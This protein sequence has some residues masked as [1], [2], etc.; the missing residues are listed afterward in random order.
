MHVCTKN[1]LVEPGAMF[2]TNNKVFPENEHVFVVVCQTHQLFVDRFNE[3]FLSRISCKELEMDK[4]NA[5]KTICF[6]LNSA[7]QKIKISILDVP[8]SLKLKTIEDYLKKDI[9]SMFFYFC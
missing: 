4:G 6:N 2:F 7:A 5:R 3:N 1:K 9:K 8:G